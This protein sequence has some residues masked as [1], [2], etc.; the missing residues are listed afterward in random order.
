MHVCFSSVNKPNE[1]LSRMC[2]FSWRYLY[3]S[4]AYW[5]MV[6]TNIHHSGFTV[7]RA[8]LL[9]CVIDVFKN[10][11]MFNNTLVL[12]IIYIHYSIT[13]TWLFRAVSHFNISLFVL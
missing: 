4:P 11:F 8:M 3:K 6:Q 13:E 7:W 10:W 9:V 1:N 12:H 2:C 5:W